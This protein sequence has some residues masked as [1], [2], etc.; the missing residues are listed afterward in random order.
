MKITLQTRCNQ[1]G[2]VARCCKHWVQYVKLLWKKKVYI[3]IYISTDPTMWV[4]FAG[5]ENRRLKTSFEFKLCWNILK[6]CLLHLGEVEQKE[7]GKLLHVSTGLLTRWVRIIT[8]I[9]SRLENHQKHLLSCSCL[10][11]LEVNPQS[12]RTWAAESQKHLSTSL[13]NTSDEQA[14]AGDCFNTDRRVCAAR[15]IAAVVIKTSLRLANSRRETP[16]RQ[17]VFFFR[18]LISTRLFP[19][20][21]KESKLKSMFGERERGEN[22]TP[23]LQ[24]CPL[25]EPELARKHPFRQFGVFLQQVSESVASQEKALPSSKLWVFH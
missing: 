24:K 19:G 12:P 13:R 21:K 16:R 8:N 4:L 22:W 11:C 10:Y 23:T 7:C 2:S 9:N 15:T 1:A 6:S 5:C 20:C 17:E 14:A 25:A 18:L 3:Y